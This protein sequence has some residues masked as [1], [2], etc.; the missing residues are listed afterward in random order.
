MAFFIVV[1]VNSS[2]RYILR[3]YSQLIVNKER[4]ELFC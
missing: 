3:I 4:L 2:P 1:G